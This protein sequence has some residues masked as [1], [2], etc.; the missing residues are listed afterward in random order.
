MISFCSIFTLMII[1]VIVI[2]NLCG[3]EG[4]IECIGGRVIG[5]VWL[6]VYLCRVGD[7]GVGGGGGGGGT[8]E[9]RFQKKTIYV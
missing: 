2:V 7:G 8:P 6:S 9:K 3:G 5:W 1:A 4:C